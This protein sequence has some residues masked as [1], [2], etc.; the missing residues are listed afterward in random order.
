MGSQT[1]LGGALAMSF[2]NIR[3]G[4]WWDT[5]GLFREVPK[6]R[7]QTFEWFYQ[8]CTRPVRTFYYLA[9]ELIANYTRANARLNLSDG[10]HFDNSGAYELLRREVK[11]IVVCDNGADP[12]FRFGDLEVLIRKVRID[13]G[14]AIEVADA[15]TVEKVMGKD[16]LP[17][18]L[19]GDKADW[20]ARAA[21]RCERSGPSSPEDKSHC[22]LLEAFNANKNNKVVS[23]ILWIKP[24]LF[25][26]LPQDVIGYALAHR[27]F[28]HETTGDQFFNEAQWE[29]YRAL[30]YVMMSALL[31]GPMGNPDALRRLVA[32][33]RNKRK[34]KDAAASPATG[35]AKTAAKPAANK[36]KQASASAAP[37]KPARKPRRATQRHVTE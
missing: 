19:N 9:N 11:G 2:A 32:R 10:G 6:F 25:T 13:L 1:T 21:A 15:G 17:L 29:S 37:G 5:K 35:K 33:P 31:A 12:D 8:K 30:G 28:P 22:L 26:G 34:D 3:L 24:R 18:F 16:A 20:R 4:Y 7:D 27:D 14:L 23:R 36:V